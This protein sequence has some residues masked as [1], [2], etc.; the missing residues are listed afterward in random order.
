MKPYKIGL[1]L[2]GGGTRGFAHLGIIKALAEKGIKPDIISGASAGSIAGSL[3]ADGK[4]PDEA[5]EIIGKKSF[6]KNTRIR[7]PK[8]GFFSFDG[9]IQ[10]LNN[11]YSV[12]RMED[13]LIPLYVAITNLNSGKVEYHREGKLTD[14]V[15]ASS[16]IP[17]LF[18][19]IVLNGQ[20]YVD[21][22]LID[23]LPVKPIEH[24]CEKIIAVNIMPI[25]EKSTFKG[26]KQ[27]IIRTLDLTVNCKTQEA[28]KRTD[29]FIEPP[30]LRHYPIFSTKK[31]KEIF[32][33]GYNYTKELDIKF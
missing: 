26:M 15:I 19:P 30:L 27:I 18:K 8:D 22:G 17:I 4:S 33:I 24:I 32:E 31:A 5:L 21:G 9:L 11:I 29:F 14:F 10:E 16:S 7:F 6:F 23:N 3:I 1:V 13:L 2:G 12:K 28:K 25:V 20:M